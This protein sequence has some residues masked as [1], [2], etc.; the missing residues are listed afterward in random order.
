MT[1]SMQSELSWIAGYRSQ[2]R[3]CH[4]VT[5]VMEGDFEDFDRVEI[6]RIALKVCLAQNV[7]LDAAADAP[8]TR[9]LQGEA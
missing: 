4:R 7:R 6:P 5:A 2:L 9:F 3:L 8:V 1:S